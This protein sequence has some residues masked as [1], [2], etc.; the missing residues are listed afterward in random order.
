MAAAGTYADA[1]NADIP[2]MLLTSGRPPAGARPTYTPLSAGGGAVL[3]TP[4]NP[5]PVT[6]SVRPVVGLVAVV[7][8]ATVG[9]ARFTVKVNGSA[10]RSAAP[11]KVTA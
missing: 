3:V 7:V 8:T 2:A 6:L 4:R 1:A 9:T 10:S 11:V 5:S